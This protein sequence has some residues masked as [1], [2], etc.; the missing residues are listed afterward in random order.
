MQLI[1]IFR[2]AERATL[3]M[4]QKKLSENSTF[5]ENFRPQS[6]EKKSETFR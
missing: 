1:C 6:E 3:W 4:M 2:H 5:R